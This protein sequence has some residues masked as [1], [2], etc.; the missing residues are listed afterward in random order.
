MK[1]CILL[2]NCQGEVLQ[3][4]LVK[5]PM[6]SLEW[7]VKYYASFMKPVIEDE[8]LANCDLLIHQALSDDWGNLSE[9]YLLSKISSHTKVIHMPNFLYFHAWPTAKWDVTHGPIWHDSYVDE[10]ISRGLSFEEVVYVVMRSDLSKV[11]DLDAMMR[12][13]LKIEYEKNYG[14]REELM[15]YIEENWRTEQF[16]TTPSHPYGKLLQMSSNLLLKELG[17]KP[18]VFENQTALV[19][20]RYYFLPV[21]P[22]IIQYHKIKWCSKE[23]TYPTYKY[24][25]NYEDY[26]RAYVT[27]KQQDIPLLYYLNKMEADRE[28]IAGYKEI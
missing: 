17:Y 13:S 25:L 15:A 19:C 22:S 8:E 4:V 18:L 16:F 6:F 23:T 11:Y 27:A 20:D 5:H 12:S 21:H 2:A 3:Q 14:W 9:S 26:L 28:I 10:V 24:Y 7:E 1:K